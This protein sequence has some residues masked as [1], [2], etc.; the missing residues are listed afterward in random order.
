V[1]CATHVQRARGED[2][3]DCL[4]CR[5]A[6]EEQRSVKALLA[7]VPAPTL[8][9]DRRAQLAAEVMARADANDEVPR[10]SHR[11][12]VVAVGAALLAAAVVLVVGSR[13]SRVLGR[14][15]EARVAPAAVVELIPSPVPVGAPP[16]THDAVVDPPAPPALAE[17]GMPPSS[18]P[19]PKKVD[20]A[21]QV[22]GATTA[23]QQAAIER[24]TID[25][26][27]TAVTA[28]TAFRRGWEALRAQRYA[29]AIAAFDRATA[30]AVAED[31]AFWSAIAAQRSG[32]LDDARKRL[33]SFLSRFPASPRADD[34][35]HAR[36]V[37][38]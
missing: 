25:V 6:L 2:V 3:H 36:E 27:D 18:P 31:A 12:F 35:R 32:D 9:P 37:L 7:Q 33:D 10:R 4:A 14:R 22:F 20:G 38:R 8:A 28:V 23:K 30:P 29:D 19:A 5:R 16:I 1:K 15:I 13:D 11:P 21:R 26:E 24:D 17:R 34:A